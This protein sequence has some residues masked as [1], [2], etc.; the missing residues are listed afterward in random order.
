MNDPANCF[1]ARF[2]HQRMGARATRPVRLTMLA[3][4]LLGITALAATAL[5]LGSIGTASAQNNFYEI[6]V[7]PST[8][9][10]VQE[11]ED[12]K[13]VLTLSRPTP[14][15][16]AN[17][18]GYVKV[19]TN[20]GTANKGSDFGDV[21]LSNSS[22]QDGDTVLDLFGFAS[23]T[24]EV[25]VEWDYKVEGDETFQVKLD[26]FEHSE[27]VL[28]SLY[29]LRFPG[30][31]KSLTIDVT[32]TERETYAVTLDQGG[33]VTEGE[34]GHNNVRTERSGKGT[35]RARIG[36]ADSTANAADFDKWD[37]FNLRLNAFDPSAA[38]RMIRVET[39]EDALVELSETIILELSNPTGNLT[40]PD[41]DGD[42]K[43][44]EA[45]YSTWVIRDNETPLFA[46]MPDVTVTEGG[47]AQV[48]LTLERQLLAGEAVEFYANVAGHQFGSQQPCGVGDDDYAQ[49]NLDYRIAEYTEYMMRSGEQSLTFTVPT[50]SDPR[51]EADECFYVRAFATSGLKFRT[52]SGQVIQADNRVLFTKVTIEDDD[53]QPHL[54]FGAP[55]VVELD[56]DPYAGTREQGYVHPT[57]T[58]R[59]P[60]SL[61]NP[62]GIEVTVDYSE[63]SDGDATVGEDYTAITPGKLTFPP[64]LLRRYIDVEVIADWLEEPDER[65]HLEFSNPVNACLVP[66]DDCQP[67]SGSVTVPGTILNDDRNLRITLTPDDDRVREGEAIN[68]RARLSHPIDYEVRIKSE[69]GGGTATEDDD[70]F[71]DFLSIYP[72]LKIFPGTT[73]AVL[74]I[75]TLEDNVSGEGVESLT[76]PNLHVQLFR[77][78]GRLQETEDVCEEVFGVPC[79]STYVPH[80]IPT[81]T[82]YILDG[83]VISVTAER[84]DVAEGNSANFTVA[85][86]EP[87]A[88]DVTFTIKSQDGAGNATGAAVA[89]AGADYAALSSQQ[90]TI[91]MGQTDGGTYPVA[92][93]QDQVDEP[94]QFFSVLL[95]SVT[96]VTVDERVAGVAVRDDDPRPEL[97]IGDAQAGEGDTLEFVLVLSQASERAITVRYVTEDAT[98]TGGADY[99]GIERFGSVAFAPGETLKTITV[100]SIEDSDPETDETFRV[101]LVD[102][103]GARFTDSAAVGTITDDDGAVISIADAEPVTETEGATPSATFTITMTPAQTAPVTV[104]WQTMDGLGA[105]HFVA[106]ASGMTSDGEKDY[107][108]V[109]S[110]SVTF[111]PG[112]TVKQVSTTVLDD[113]IAEADENF[114]AVISVSDP[115]IMV[116]RSTAHATIEDDDA[117][118]IWLDENN[119][120]WVE[121]GTGEDKRI[122]LK[123][124]RTNASAEESLLEA[125]YHTR[126]RYI[127]CF[128]SVVKEERH[129]FTRM[130]N[131]YEYVSTATVDPTDWDVRLWHSDDTRLKHP[132]CHLRGSNA[133][134]NV[135]GFEKLSYTLP[136][137]FEI[138][139]DSISEENETFTLLL[140]SSLFG[141]NQ[142]RFDPVS[143]GYQYVTVTI[144]DDDTPQASIS[145]AYV[146]E[147]DGNAELTLSLSM[148]PTEAQKVTIS[149]EG[150][151]A[152]PWEDYTPLLSHD[153]TFEV[154]ETTK[155]VSIPIVNDDMREEDEEFT[156]TLSNESGGINIHPAGETA[157]VTISDDEADYLP[158]LTV[159]DRV[160]DEGD[161][162]TLLF[163]LNPPPPNRFWVG[164][165]QWNDDEK[166]LS[167]PTATEVDDY[168]EI[169]GSK[170][171]AVSVGQGATEFTTTV[172]TVEDTLIEGG[173]YI[174][175]S[176][177]WNNAVGNPIGLAKPN[178]LVAIR[179]DD[180]G[181]V[182]VAPI[183]AATAVENKEWSHTAAL[184][185]SSNPLGDVSWSVAGDDVAFFSIDQDTGILTMSAR[186]YEDPLD[187]DGD[188]VYDAKVFAVDED[189]N[190][191]SEDVQVTVT[192]VTYA[193]F[194]VQ[195]NLCCHADFSKRVYG[196]EE[197]DG[198]QVWVYPSFTSSKPV[199]LKWATAE[200]TAGSNLA[201]T[202]DYTPSTTPTQLSWPAG[203]AG[204]TGTPQTFT[205][206]TTEDA[207]Y[208]A[209][210]TFLLSFTEGMAGDTDDVKLSFASAPPGSVRWDGNEADATLTIGN[211][212]AAVNMVTLSVSPASV[213]EG[214]GA[215]TVTVTATPAG[216]AVFTQ[217]GSLTVKVGK[218]GDSAVSGTDY[219]AINDVTILLVAGASTASAQFTLTPTQDN[220]TEG[221]ETITV[222]GAAVGLTVADASLTITDDDLPVPVLTI[223]DGNAAA[224]RRTVTVDEGDAAEFTVTAT[225]LP[226]RDVTVQ[227]ATGDDNSLNA[228]QA[229]ADTD[230][231]ALAQTVTI[232]AGTPSATVQVQTT[233]D[234][235]TEGDESFIVF[236]RSPTDA[237]IGKQG[238][239]TGIITD[240]DISSPYASL[241]VSPASVD[242]GAGATT[243]TVTAAFNGGAALQANQTIAVKVGHGRDGAVSGTDYAPVT[244]FDLIIPAGQNSAQKTFTLTPLQDALDEDDETLTVHGTS[245]GLTVYSASVSITDDDAEPELFIRDFSAAEGDKAHFNITLKPVSGRDVTVQWATGDDDGLNANQATA[246]VDYEAV[247]TAQTAT[248]SAGHSVAHLDLRMT[249]DTVVEGDETFLVTLSSPTSAILLK[250]TARA[251][252]T[253]DDISDPYATLSV[254]PASASE[255]TPIVTSTVTATLSGGKTFSTD[256]T[257]SVKVGLGGDSAVLGEDYAP[258]DGFSL[259]IPAG[260]NSGQHTFI[261]WPKEDSLNEDTETITIHG[262]SPGLTVYKT[263][264]SITDYDPLPTLTIGN[265]TIAEG[266]KAF[267][268][269]FLTPASGRPV[270]FQWTTGDDNGLNA[271]PATAGADYEAVTA[272]QTV[273]IPAGNT[274]TG[275]DLRTK[276]DSLV[277]G[278][279]TFAVI[280]ASP[281][282]ATLGTPSVGR[283]TIT[284]DDISSPFVSLSLNPASASE[285]TPVVSA[286]VTA[287]LS[288]SGTF[289]TDK[290]I[291]VKVGLGGDSAVSGEDYAPVDS[292]DLTIPAG[293]SSGQ[294]TFI[295]WPKEDSLNEN[296][297]TITI[298]GTAPGLTVYKTS[299]SIVDDDPLPALSIG[300]VSIAEGGKAFF[301]ISLTPASGREVTVQWTTGDDNSLN[302]NPATAVTDY[303]AVTAAQT[304]TFRPG[305]TYRGID[306]RT[307]QDSLIEG[308]ESFL[309]TLASPTN[310]TLGKPSARTTI[311]DDDIS[312]PYATLSVNP[313]SVAEGAGATT[314]AVTATLSGGKTFPTDKTISVKVGLGG[315]GAVSG[316]DYAAVSS[317]N[318]TIPSGQS[319]GQQTFTLTPIQDALDEDNET[320]TVHSASPELTV[321]SASLAITDDDA[322]PVLTI[323]DANVSEG[324]TAEF[325]VTLNPVSGRDVTV[326]WTTGDDPTQGANQAT[327]DTDYT[328]VTTAQTATIAAGSTTAAIK[329]QTTQDTAVESDETFIVTLATPTNAT[330]GSPS[331]GTGTITDSGAP[332]EIRIVTITPVTGV[333]V[334]DPVNP[335]NVPENIA[336]AP[337][338]NFAV[339]L[340]GTATA[341]DRQVTVTVGQDGDTAVSGTDY[342]AVADF[343]ITIA[344]GDVSGSGQFTFDPIDDALDEDDERV[345]VSADLGGLSVAG[346]TLT[347]IDDDAEPV[348]TIGDATVT[349]GGVAQFIVTLDAVSGRDVTVQW[350]TGDDPAQGANQATADTDYTAVTTAQTATV[351]AGSTTTTIEVQTAQD[352][353]VENNETFIVALASPTNATLGSPSTGTATITDDDTAAPTASLSVSPASVDEGDGA[354][355]VTVTATLDGSTTFAADRTVT[356]TVG[357]ASDSADANTDYT[358]VITSNTITITAGQSSGHTTFALTPTQDTGNEG[359]E[360]I[361]LSAT[362]PGLT[363]SDAAL[364]IRDDDQRKG[365]D[366]TLPVI[367]IDGP[368]VT[369]PDT[370]Q[371][372]QMLF[373]VALDETSSQ[374][375]T[376]AYADAATGTATSGTDYVAITAGTL[377]FAPGETS[378]SVAV[379]VIGD[380]LEEGDETIVLRLSSPTNAALSG[381][382]ATLDGTGKIWDNDGAYANRPRVSI[383]ADY[384]TLQGGDV[385]FSIRLS[386]RL[387]KEIH[388]PIDIE[389][390]TADDDL[391]CIRNSIICN[392]VTPNVRTLEEVAPHRTLLSPYPEHGDGNQ[393]PREIYAKQ[394]LHGSYIINPARPWY[395]TVP[396]GFTRTLPDGSIETR[397]TVYIRQDGDGENERFRIVL[398]TDHPLW[399]SDLVPAEYS[400]YAEVL[401]MDRLNHPAASRWWAELSADERRRMLSGGH[402]VRKIQSG[403]T[404][405]QAITS[406][407]EGLNFAFK[408]R[409]G[410][411]AGE[412]AN[413]EGENEL[414]DAGLQPL[415]L[416]SPDKWWDSMDCRLRRV[417]VGDGTT[418]D[419][420]SRWCQNEAAELGSAGMDRAVG[421]FEAV[422]LE[423][424]D[425]QGQRQSQDGTLTGPEISII[426]Y[427]DVTEGDR[428]S[429]TIFANPPPLTDLE[430]S[431]TV[432]T[433]GDFGVAA[434]S[435]TV[436]IS[437]LGL[438]FLDLPTTGDDK[439][440]A[441]GSVTATVNAGQGY[442]VSATNGTATV[443][444]ADDD[445]PPQTC[446]PN[447]PSDA[448][449]V[450]EVKTWR[451]E[452]SQDSHVSRWN[453][454]LAALGEDTGEAAM[455]ADQAR[456]IKSRIDNSRWDR[457]VRTLEALEQCN[458]PP[459]ATPEISIAG[460][461]GITEGGNVTF[462]VTAN[463][464]PTSALSVSVGI[465]QSGDYGVSTGS[466]TV[467]IPTGGSATLTVATSDDGVDEADGSVTATVNTGTGYT[468]SATAGSATVAVAD[469]DVPE[470]SIVSNGD[471]TEGGDASFTVTANPAPHAPLSVSVAI[472]QSGDYGV[473]PGSQTVSI[474]TGGSY[475][476]TVATGDDGVDEA[477]GS[478]TATVNSGTGYTVSATTG[479]ATV[480]VADDDDPPQ[481]CTPNL[482]SDAITVSEVE[483]WRDEYSHD[484][485]VSRWNRVLAALGEDTGEAAMTADQAREIKSRIDNT[486]W[487]R[488]VR[489]LEALEQCSNPP[490][491]TPEISIT[492]GSGITEGG[493]AS[494]TIAANPASSS[495][496]SV[497]VSIAQTGDYGASTG[498]QT[499]SIP[500]SGSYTL[501]VATVN[502]A[503]DETD[504]SVTATVNSGTGYTVSGTAG[505]ATVVVADD[506]VPEVSV[507]AGSGITEGGN[508]SFTVSANPA[509]AANLDVSVAVSQSGDFGVSTVSQTVTI[510]TSGSA[511]LTVATLNDSVDEA[512]GS[513]TATVN[514]GAGYTVSGTA[515]SATL[516]VADDDD[517]APQTCTP[518][519]PSDAVTVSEVETWR[520]EYSHD[521]HVSRW[522]RVLAALG[523]DTGETAMTADDARTIKQQYDNTRWDRTV[524][525]LDALEQCAGSTGTTDDTTPAATPEVS[526]TSGSG[527]TEGGNVTF[528]VTANPAPTSPLSVSVNVGQTGDFGVTTGSQTVSIPTSGSYTLTVATGDDGVDEA[529][530]SVTATVNS[531]T[532]Y[533][534]S[535]TAGAATVAVADDDVPGISITGGSG[536]TE[537]GN[538][539]FTLTAS[540]APH[541]PLSVSVSVSQSGDFGVTPGSQTVSIPTT[542]SYTLTVATVND[543]V[544]EADG[545]VTATVSGGQGYTVSGTAGSATVAVADDDDAAPPAMPEI[546][547]T[548][549]NGI[550][551]GGNATFTL[552]ASP[553]PHAPL[554]VSVSVA[555]TGDFGVSAGPQTVSIPTTG[556]ATLTVAT[557]DDSVDEADG[558]VTATVNGGT[559]YTVSATAGA[560]TVAV[561]D[562][563]VPEIS[564]AAGSGVTEG[565]DASFTLSANPAPH[566]PL[567]VSVSV[568]QSGD[569]GATP[570]SRTVTIPTTGSA[571]FTVATSDDSVDEADG[572]VTATVDSGQGYTVS[573]TAGAAT[574][575]VADDDD[576]PPPDATP[577]L[578]VSDASAREDAGVMEFTVSLSAPSEK[579]VQVYAATTSFRY[580]TATKGDDFEWA[581]VL[582]TFAPGETSK[583]VQVVILD[584]DLSEGD[585]SFGMFLAYS[586]SDTPLTRE[587][588]EGVI[589]DDD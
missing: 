492:G 569:Y 462:T 4:A 242:E 52:Q 160:I 201:A 142:R 136:L 291:R 441:D 225:P 432:S 401:A 237:T 100:M 128:I 414:T 23:G 195:V 252:I 134:F 575:A 78:D 169:T 400:G 244:S 209:D 341:T 168:A 212:D 305:L 1:P 330:L 220:Q 482:P 537:G 323:G 322:L 178:A 388:I 175:I 40:F 423:T 362:A 560:A 11:G 74:T 125:R 147:D 206:A 582:L 203:D 548:A 552:T 211:D 477:D 468:V 452:Y 465:T 395:Q 302:A 165:I 290:T 319:S 284:D 234:N 238:P 409:V 72:E 485:H 31:K 479:S 250:P 162:T 130:T 49:P 416:T 24:I 345:T 325:M 288:G 216:S 500:T 166:P 540:P 547:I 348:L 454:V 331:V 486:R 563:D 113:T 138:R 89:V 190:V 116:L 268:T 585:E 22:V 45:I 425:E 95:E 336:T 460:G 431:M 159:P 527:I 193:T 314:V 549:G 522:N 176:T 107:T 293:Q 497:S 39:K 566:A 514:T 339:T 444:V 222:H 448:I 413:A 172:S 457:T 111:A 241:S 163:R 403:Q 427:V 132:R 308:D 243:V 520:D 334:P 301:A 229:T 155:T 407:Y 321:K 450:S 104:Q 428:A 200:D 369:E 578:S 501:T 282:N 157:T 286:T 105:E 153:V 474:P 312:D 475:T 491:A 487:D 368:E 467:S 579:K 541:A 343:T 418:D 588:G 57:A 231:A 115:N 145:S 326:Q 47:E 506:D 533:T 390:I 525:T 338:Y 144:V 58:L 385:W 103:P 571:S 46:E 149:M 20:D 483:T 248:I 306:L 257:V 496:L 91:P 354:T 374:E 342:T 365:N 383:S 219:A 344:A 272:A 434:G 310:A 410:A 458:N 304:L 447:L 112:E 233:Q 478:V 289:P 572:S 318:L 264:L 214:D 202:T 85:L 508:A 445:D 415:D 204:T 298:H 196:A 555:Q 519:L 215:T 544:D 188:N 494:F 262:T 29:N 455:T 535:S 94:D 140:E 81:P 577:S 333:T 424:A 33:S 360:A 184:T 161:D 315:D 278:D 567:A 469:D 258:V 146:G 255:S 553:A 208:E 224:P 63:G 570:G 135:D 303:E 141:P 185:E 239:A 589:I 449:T 499:V 273:T 502:D 384:S 106:K 292:F 53:P 73:E 504:G 274:D 221:D 538:A 151:T 287:T 245:P 276:Q 382:G 340:T 439:D 524:R 380:T 584:D 279:E 67:Q 489:T 50:A 464:A 26:I 397:N 335:R 373:T 174:G 265:T 371:A 375:I 182:E 559:G 137:E 378:K 521:D 34:T 236:L 393:S 44:D 296:T 337:T 267:F 41:L 114:R 156:V 446:T 379:N 320:I 253:D 545:S 313:A 76:L 586:P 561:E 309:V 568:S 438:A 177:K 361:T 13:L 56:P 35:V 61:S 280:L 21:S 402:F 179:D 189:G 123:V 420:T 51:H 194:T 207:L 488:T 451:G 394:P 587:H 367:S 164:T 80:G 381:D 42:G 96:G 254:S 297:E 90:V 263:S 240:D 295:L 294:K 386:K 435:Q 399:P 183:A 70:Y 191:D 583:V 327:A 150:G 261:W 121:E 12:S 300:D 398:D 102:D 359:D 87:V 430:V 285:S 503:V 110:G 580:K 529:D 517:A 356:F 495:A 7:S 564:I 65:V 199:S 152:Q 349:E 372:T 92:V 532:G 406:S 36:V 77:K 167:L 440:E 387:H 37:P 232:P 528:T 131:P 69:W 223:G 98:A 422:T 429:F 9:V 129:P 133:S 198:I 48:T 408:A 530:G 187:Q 10:E 99:Q 484:D 148:A 79:V 551:E 218:S 505:S 66:G 473:S 412:L 546:S 71:R 419:P 466:Q 350:T 246:G 507:S 542:G 573:A 283:G 97:S 119:A 562:D 437:A 5:A 86:S 205:I 518:N 118:N 277:E 557:S 480:A 235:L 38:I 64:G 260:Q 576:P 230:Y 516:A 357:K 355:T 59:F 6:T 543:S 143:R 351:A 515:G 565:G 83:P 554:D 269:V 28:N 55:A 490:T 317:F 456:E 392:S 332:P 377:T 391:K 316:T 127:S 513:V 158:R 173:E 426:S 251:T 512:D 108:A 417:A 101:Q 228:N 442:T 556:S 476:L 3:I 247:T 558:S 404:I 324:E 139:G 249:Q 19:Q 25:P 328:A 411:L 2:L 43:P 82:A 62:S 117:W 453:R 8:N 463:P 531:G 421:I 93:L 213:G 259:T 353:A 181:S 84:K 376:V 510:P 109:S 471:I 574:V 352:A 170:A 550:T 186:N 539:T 311:V 75:A 27:P 461:S 329:V 436:T 526:V 180:T 60:V 498:S 346:A 275:I 88:Q 126:Y 122:T 443:V 54:I 389:Y 472:S 226:Y 17:A 197:G 30:N 154:G 120:A 523:E 396:D 433:T 370:S 192:D 307:R 358:T 68:F 14:A 171:D 15:I 347:I 536:V 511:T 281:T 581:N 366:G 124:Q 470:I 364:T 16:P 217:G 18:W 509:P 459:A 299:L 270:T 227:V 271:N 266:G 210:E 493:N 363:V 256:K 534:V 32:I 405:S 481:T